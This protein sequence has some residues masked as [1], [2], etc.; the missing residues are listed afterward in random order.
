LERLER[1]M[2]RLSRLGIS[3]PY[4]AWHCTSVYGIESRDCGG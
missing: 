4:S 3:A 1:W 2:S